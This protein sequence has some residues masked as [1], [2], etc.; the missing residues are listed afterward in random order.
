MD[1]VELTAGRLHLRPWQPWDAAEVTAA[2]QDPAVQRWTQVPVPY[3]RESAEHFVGT[4]SPQGWQ[5]GTD[6]LFAVLDATTAAVLASVG[7]T[8]IADGAAEVG[9]WTAPG[10]RRQGVTTQAVGV[11]CRWAFAQLGLERVLWQ[12]E[13]GNVGSRAV[14]EAAGFTVEGTQRLG[15]V[16]RGR[17]V[18]CWTGSL[19]A[20]DEPRDRRPFGS[21]RDLQGEG[22]VLRPW[23]DD[24]ADRACVLAALGDPASAR[25]LDVPV[26][27][28]E[29]DARRF[30]ADTPVRWAEGR[31]ARLA[32]EQDG[33]PVGLVVVLPQS[34]GVAELGWWVRPDARGSAVAARATRVLLTWA[35]P[36]YR[37]LEAMVDVENPASQ[38]VAEAAGLVREGVLRAALRPVR[39]GAARD[40]VLYALA[41]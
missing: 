17:R 12:A 14:A 22:L 11:V 28:D 41:P 30:L 26:P 40:G 6:A 20:T 25:W 4:L 10:A 2:C 7:L 19:L 13:V 16:S 31:S 37:R 9:Y 21:W 36:R 33:R 27:Y 29:D 38:R 32:V 39:D 3:T 18:D 5:A 24:A 8:G 34:E 15:L 1:P 35:G 23:R